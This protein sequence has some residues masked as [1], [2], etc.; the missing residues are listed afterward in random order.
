MNE[1]A[2]VSAGVASPP[3]KRKQFLILV[4]SLLV[5]AAW[6]WA[7]N[8]LAHF[9]HT[10]YF[11][12]FLKNGSVI[13]ATTAF[14]ALVW[15]RLGEQEGLL[16][17]HPMRFLASC[18]QTAG[19]F[20]L[21]LGANLGGPL[22]GVK[23]RGLD[24]VSIA[25]VLWDGVFAMIM[26]VFMMLA[27]LGWLLVVAP[28]FYL[29]TLFTGAPARREMRG[30]GR[31]VVVQTEGMLTTI[32]D[33]PSSMEAPSGAIDVSFATQPFVLTNALNAAAVLVLNMVIEK[34]H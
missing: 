15:K 26:D 34:M 27:I 6:I 12:W 28:G 4:I 20:S 10:D 30:T 7:L 33:Q 23:Q 18:L 24:A 2:E 13:S 3:K 22:D 19:V 25:E 1:P 14:F 8:R 31:K 32:T 16:A 17:W 11:H 9:L 5:L 29:L 21:A